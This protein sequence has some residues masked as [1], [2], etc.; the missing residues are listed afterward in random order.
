MSDAT[1]VATSSGKGIGSSN[2]TIARPTGTLPGDILIL[3]TVNRGERNYST[4]TGWTERGLHNYGQGRFRLWTRTV[5]AENPE[6]YSVTGSGT[7]EHY[8]WVCM[9]YTNAA[10]HQFASVHGETNLAAPSVTNTVENTRRVVG[11]FRGSSTNFSKSTFDEPSG[12]TSRGQTE[13]DQVAYRVADKIDTASGAT[14]TATFEA[15]SNTEA[16][17][18]WTLS[19]SGANVPPNAPNLVTPVSGANAS[20]DQNL[21]L[22]WDFSDPDTGDSQSR[23]VGEV[24]IAGGSVVYSWDE[25]STSTQRTIPAST[26][27]ADDYEW[28]VKTY[29]ALGVEGPW[30][31]WETFTGVVTPGAPTITSH[32]TNDVISSADEEFTWSTSEQEEYQYQRVADN[33][34]VID[35]DTIYF[36]SGAIASVAIRSQIVNFPVNDR[37]EWVRWRV[38]NDGLWS[39][40]AT[41]R[42][43]VDYTAPATPTITKTESDSNGYI[44]IDI[45]NPTPSGGQPT[46]V[47]NDIYKRK[48][49]E[50]GEPE[51]EWVRVGTLIANNGS[52]VDYNVAVGQ[53]YEW[54]AVAVGSNAG[55]AESESLH[56]DG[57]TFR[58]SRIH[59]VENPLLGYKFNTNG[60]GG[61]STWEPEVFI[62]TYVG[63]TLPVSEFGESENERIIIQLALD[64]EEEVDALIRLA[65]LKAI[66]C[67]RDNFGRLLFCIIPALNLGARFFGGESVVTLQGVDHMEEV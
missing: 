41:V 21:T 45:T 58:G 22:D 6:S 52:F 36:D 23:S 62:Q 24:R 15:S 8:A 19:L 59:P 46:V 63:R 13:N 61:S 57:I 31:S 64:G 4:P 30:S 37:F 17:Y 49:S 50:E 43:E 16:C 51:N 14:G 48:T 28:R 2:L 38:K 10:I 35:T 67:Y 12:F 32:S 3:C 25:S 44:T 27:A 1:F 9:A 56:S 11:S 42:V 60:E 55:T 66:L 18:S 39:S 40:Y 47:H 29:D 65:K 54:Y 33:A 26:L 34:G 53:S 7:G 20:V 5:A